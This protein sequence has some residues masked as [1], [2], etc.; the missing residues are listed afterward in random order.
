[1]N[2]NKP[3]YRSLAFVLGVCLSLCTLP[4]LATE[5]VSHTAAQGDFPLVHGGQ[6]AS[7]YLDSAEPEGLRLAVANLQKDI[8]K[9][10]GVQSA[11]VKSITRQPALVIVGTL[12]HS[13][14][15]QQ[16]VAAGKLDVSTLQGQWEG[17]RI[18]TIVQPFEGVE[19]ALV[20]AGSDMR[21]AIFGVYDVSEQI[22][23]SP[24]YWWADVPIKQAKSL[25]VQANTLVQQQPKVRYRGIFLNDEAPALTGWVKEKFGDYNSD[26][27]QHVFELL[28]RLK[29]NFLWPAMWNNAFSLDDPNNPQLANTMGIVMS[30]SHHEPMM[31]AD[32]EWN[33]VGEGKWD[34]AVNAENL[35]QFWQEG[36]R[37]HKDLE[38]IFTLGMRGQQDEPMGETENI[39]LLEKIV[40]DQR[41]ILSDT[42]GKAHLSKVPQV[43]ALYKEVQ[44]YYENGMR[45][46]DDVTLLW[47]DDN[48]GNLRR[49][50]TPEE[51]ERSGGAGVYYHFDYVGGPRSYR[52]INTVPLAKIWEQMRLAY[53][54]QADRIWLTNVGDL[55][56]MEYPIDFFL[57]MAWDPAAMQLDELAAYPQQWAKQQF[58][59][60]FSAQIAELMNTYTRHNGRRK[61]ELLT[62][63]TYSVLNYREAERVSTE[64]LDAISQAE[65]LYQQ[66]PAEYQDAYFQLVLH[67]LKA[68]NIVY[69]MYYNAA[70]NRLY[71]EQG[72]ATTN[73]Y[74]EQVKAWFAADK[75]L[76][77]QYHS[78]AGGRWNHFMS[79]PHIGYTH[80]NNPP[81]NTQPAVVYNQPID[82]PDMGVAVQGTAAAWPANGN[83]PLHFD[84]F[85]QQ[86]RYIDVF[87]KGT[88]PFKLSVET[89][90]EWISLSAVPGEITEQ[91][92]LWVS[93]DWTK[94][95]AEHGKGF[96]HIKGTGWGGARVAISA[97]KPRAEKLNGFVEADGY[98][99]LEAASGEAK[100]QSAQAYWQEIPGHGRTL[101]SMTAQLA[102]EQN[103]I[104]HPETAPYLEFPLYFFSTGQIELETIVAPSL[105]FDPSRGI[106]M[107]I[108]F[109]Q[110]VP[111][112]IDILAN[113]TEADWAKSVEDGVRKVLSSHH[114]AKAG[115]NTLRIY[116]LESGLSVQKL[117]INTGGVQPSYLGPPQSQLAGK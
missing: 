54:Y 37:R 51:R 34:Y 103:F 3:I 82:A 26:F 7:I 108:S 71:A 17:M 12:E 80:W 15:L 70:L 10:S 11:L 47:S 89:S 88:Q 4:L 87:N 102:P 59:A 57:R 18:Q 55:K 28:L 14:A 25:Y 81:A 63:D 40:A 68:S 24:W 98:I 27:Y 35:Y 20:I 29:A 39:A 13:R 115:A 86:Q 44:S 58:P 99:A 65:A 69:Q 41:Q 46:P 64:L 38:S 104:A 67:P 110:Q 32:K 5:Y 83:L 9:V 33:R 74:A 53:A 105:N 21:G 22:G 66:L 1:M 79:Q 72:R 113:N 100:Q 49:L 85:G 90:A 95:D 30:T 114:I 94:L 111:Q 50:P 96:V 8:S 84:R 62:P 19:Q 109:N 78:L 48:W 2:I 76:E 97:F 91:Q 106:R 52:W 61:P 43:W 60:Q 16:L 42:F 92:R 112:I 77:Q 45:V 116:M 101:S 56:P 36:A 31:R 75:M 117:V 23:V 73:S 107:A 93:I 6:A